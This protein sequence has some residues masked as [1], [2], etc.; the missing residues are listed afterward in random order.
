MILG[1]GRMTAGDGWTPTKIPGCTLWLRADQGITHVGNAVS[2][3]VDQSTSGITVAQAV[4]E[5]KP[6]YAAGGGPNG[7]D[8]LTFDGGDTLTATG[9]AATSL[10][11]AS[12]GT[13]A[14]VASKTNTAGAG[15]PCMWYQTVNVN[16]MYLYT[17]HAANTVKFEFGADGVG[18]IETM[19]VWNHTSW[20]YLVFQCIDST[21]LSLWYNGTASPES[22]TVTSSVISSAN[23]TLDVGSFGGAVGFIGSIAEI[24]WYS[25]AISTANRVLLQNY[26]ATRYAI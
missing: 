26:F 13:V 25:S 2:A 10:F 22:G 14:I 9:I 18:S 20:T 7:Q 24:V 17:T 5:A 12:A 19:T 23:G 3:W 8:C 16:N 21:H 11:G 15:I 1:F 6:T 4:A